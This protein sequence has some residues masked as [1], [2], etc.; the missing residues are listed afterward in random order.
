[1]T[2]E[3][4]HQTVFRE[5]TRLLGPLLDAADS[6]WERDRL[7]G[8]LGFDLAAV[9]GLDLGPVD[10][11]IA[12]VVEASTALAQAPD[13]TSFGD[14]A[15][16]LGPV[17]SVLD[18]VGGLLSGLTTSSLPSGLGEEL[19][20]AAPR[21][22]D[23]LVAR[24]LNDQHLSAFAV[25]RLLGVIVVRT[26]PGSVIPTSTGA[27]A[28]VPTPVPWVDLGHLFKLLTD[29]VA[30]LRD[31][32]LPGASGAEATLAVAANL[33]PLLGITMATFGR[34]VVFGTSE[35]FRTAAGDLGDVGNQIADT[36]IG[37]PL[38][39]D[40]SGGEVVV[41]V[42]LVPPVPP[43]PAAVV[44]TVSGQGSQTW[45]FGNWSVNLT[46]LGAAEALAVDATGAVTVEDDT[47]G[48][49]DVRVTFANDPGEGGPV[50]LIGSATG[51]RFEIAAVE[52]QAEAGFTAGAQADLAVAVT[53]KGA[54]LFL[55]FSD[56]D[57]FLQYIAGSFMSGPVDVAADVTLGWSHRDGVRLRATGGLGSAG[58]VVELPLTT[59]LGPLSLS[60]LELG[61]AL[62]G[63]AAKALATV[64]ADLEIGPVVVAVSGVGV[65]FRLTAPDGGGNLGPLDAQLEL[66]PPN[67]MGIA[68]EAPALT[69][70][71]FL[72]SDAANGQYVG[73]LE[74]SIGTICVQ[75]VGVLT[76]RM[77]GGGTGFSLVVLA[78]V[79]G[80]QFQ[81]G[82]G[83]VLTGV[84]ALLGVNRGL[85]IDGLQTLARSGDLDRVLFPAD[86]VANAPRVAQDL[87][88]YFPVVEGQFV[89]GIGARLYWGAETLVTADLGLYVQLPSVVVAV[90]GAM[91]VTLPTAKAPVADIR[92]D[93]IGILD[94][95]GQRVSIDAGLTHSTLAG[96]TLSGQAA[97][98]ASW[99]DAPEFVLAIGGFHPSFPTPPRFPK[100]DRIG[101]SAG[102]DNPRLR[103]SG[104]LAV[105]PNTLQLGAAADLWVEAGPV[106]ITAGVSFDALVQWMPF[107]LELDLSIYA[108]ILIDGHPLRAMG[109]T[110]H[111]SGPGPWHLSGEVSFGILF[112]TITVPFSWTFGASLKPA[113]PPTVDALD[114]LVPQLADPGN[115]LAGAPSGPPVVILRRGTEGTAVHPLGSLAVRQRLVP[116]ERPITR[117]GADVLTQATVLSVSC[118]AGAGTRSA[119]D[120]PVT[121][122][123][124]PA[125]FQDLTDAEKLSSRPFEHMVAG[126]RIDD[127]GLAV[128]L[129]AA[130]PTGT[131]VQCTPSDRAFDSTIVDLDTAPPVSGAP[132]GPAPGVRV[133]RPAVTG[134]VR[135]PDSEIAAQ[136][137]S[138]ASA[139]NGPSARGSARYTG[140]PLGIAVVRPLFTTAP[141][142]LQASSAPRDLGFAPV[143]TESGTQAM[144]SVSRTRSRPIPMQV[145][146]RSEALSAESLP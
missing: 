99:G 145:V 96:M 6:P 93:V 60:K 107:H 15:A 132:S 40:D 105:T 19:E 86:V 26:P 16:A 47:A 84:G 79:T 57:G 48:T 101:L 146:Y 46:A 128:P 127:T 129:D 85:N 140:P 139:V 88:T 37:F 24:W 136:L 3:S 118:D 61:V 34:A 106:A 98:R 114:L 17:V 77:P 52:V 126:V 119:A 111:L 113:A 69:G 130:D 123:F 109:I 80:L 131:A 9:P 102:G 11:A 125:Q 29:P 33:W 56:G 13:P 50:L 66:Q 133:T 134:S 83:I 121:E 41:T 144:A 18:G 92:L 67:G 142:D 1:M 71:G 12:A 68:I 14:F 89:V 38:V 100:L 108:A 51:T 74:L 39:F 104:Y 20:A 49:L 21:L 120:S 10:D 97:L 22:M 36:T 58:V 4:F 122:F 135:V 82:F 81:L 73:A 43:L 2:P 65:A 64:D 55:D 45:S 75:G 70:G 72:Q 137:A 76:T 138:A 124:A 91:R 141:A 54:H 23:Y 59:S 112:F 30:A 32:Y 87:A 42:T 53:A 143:L 95:P 44:V 78:N 31:R 8:A 117:I 90:L 62:S 110:A 28:F 27:V 35:D 115:Y 116:L 63:D 5:V 94:I 7:L 25:L 103:L